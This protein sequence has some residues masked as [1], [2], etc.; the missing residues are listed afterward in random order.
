MEIQRGTELQKSL[1]QSISNSFHG[2]YTF[3]FVT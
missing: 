3:S 2:S 1:L